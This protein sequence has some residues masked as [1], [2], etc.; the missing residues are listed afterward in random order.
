MSIKVSMNKQI[1]KNILFNILNFGVN[2]ILGI[3]LTPYLIKHMGIVAY[4]MIPLAMFITSYVGVL[5][6]SLTAAVNRTLINA[7][8]KNDKYQVNV[9]FNTALIMMLSLILLASFI[10]VWPIQNVDHFI[11][12]PEYLKDETVSLF[13]C[14]LIAFFISLLSSVFSVPL[15]SRNRIDL[16][17]ITNIIKN[18][19]KL[20]F[21]IIFFVLERYELSSIGYSIIISELVTLFVI[22]TL[23]K[24]IIPDIHINLN[25]FDFSV[26]R[27]LTN[28][29]GWLIID[30]VGVI[31]LSK[32]DL[33]IVNRTFG[34]SS[35]GKYSIVT[36]FSDLLR[37]MASLFGGVLG[38]VMMILHSKN[39]QQKMV[40]LT[41]IFMKTMSLMMAIPIIV[42]CVFSKE[43]ITLWV[44]SGYRDIAYLTW[45]VIF[46]LIINL[47]TI[48]LFSINIAMNKVKIPSISN[49]V[50]GILGLFITLYLVRYC[51]MG[52]EGIAIGFVLSTT[53]KNS[54][55]TPIYAAM[56]MRL[57]K[58][59][60]FVLH[61][62]TLIFS[63][64][65]LI[66]LFTLKEYINADGG[67]LLF[68]LAFLC[69][70]GLPIA[71]LFYTK[72]EIYS[73]MDFI[74][75]I[76]KR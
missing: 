76:Q 49:L 25:L 12:I 70:V 62:R 69:L 33:L 63:F 42:I 2:I 74:K 45:F 75:G 57:P 21:I 56:I 23:S 19:T 52:L 27:N 53:L 6:Q 40:D 41:K 35:G 48:P 71:I 10:F 43:I 18:I 9:I 29:G 17:Q 4:G 14:V 51:S 54:F 30:Q 16:M 15:Y 3:A 64:T 28:L 38:P 72:Q 73:L 67:Y 26:V 34:S 50:F 24:K 1:I 59:T 8:H 32:L 65:Y 68:K 7:L 47:G 11:S 36:Q 39:D 5:T 46:P 22:I 61:V 31:F 60:F 37:S 44:G 20:F 58:L 55:F 66:L 13:S